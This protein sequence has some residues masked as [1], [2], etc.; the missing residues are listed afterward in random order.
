MRLK[1][2]A[3][4]ANDHAALLQDAQLGLNLH[5][6]GASS[7]RAAVA[8]SVRALDCGSRGPPFDPGQ[9]YHFPR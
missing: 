8:Q 6:P 9:R 3:E 5:E 1:H 7:P 2:P 4:S